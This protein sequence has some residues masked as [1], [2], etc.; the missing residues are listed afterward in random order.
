MRQ[1]EQLVR[2]D[3]AGQVQRLLAR[4]HAV[5]QLQPHHEPSETAS[6]SLLKDSFWS[7]ELFWLIVV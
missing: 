5:G 7:S 2:L 4:R 6:F 1:V 3:D